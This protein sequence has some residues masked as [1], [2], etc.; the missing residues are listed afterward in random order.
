MHPH[1][2]G[3]TQQESALSTAPIFSAT[4]LSRPQVQNSMFVQWKKISNSNLKWQTYVDEQQIQEYQ[5][6]IIYNSYIQAY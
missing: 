6:T 4:L 1:I 3:Y 5:P 2:S